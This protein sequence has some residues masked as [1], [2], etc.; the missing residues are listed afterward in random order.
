MS[1]CAPR[2][3]LR[4]LGVSQKHL[5]RFLAFLTRKK[6]NTVS[7][8]ARSAP[9]SRIPTLRY[10]IRR[11]GQRKTGTSRFNSTSF[12]STSP[13]SAPRELSFCCSPAHQSHSLFEC[14]AYASRTNDRVTQLRMSIA[15]LGKRPWSLLRSLPTLQY[16]HHGTVGRHVLKVDFFCGAPNAPTFNI[17]IT[18]LPG[19]MFFRSRI[20]ASRGSLRISD[21]PCSDMISV[22]IALE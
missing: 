19:I 17:G 15:S 2:F 22:P 7:R 18:G 11:P 3:S 1:V 16:W 6:M 9:A 10:D 12:K 4:L 13:A 8:V 5:I 14:N 21:M 20:R